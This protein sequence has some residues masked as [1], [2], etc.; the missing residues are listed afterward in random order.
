MYCSDASTLG[1]ALRESFGTEAE[2][3]RE[4][5][6]RERWRFAVVPE[7]DPTWPPGGEAPSFEAGFRP[8]GGGEY[9]E[10]D[11]LLSDD[12]EP[13]PRRAKEN[14]NV[15]ER[16]GLVPPL[17]DGLVEEAR[18]R[19]VLQGGWARLA[20]IH[21]KEGRIAL[22]GLRRAMRQKAAHGTVVLSF[23]DN[24][25]CLIAFDKGRATNKEL[26][27]LCR[28]S[29]AYQVGAEAVWRLRYIGSER[30]PTDRDSG[31]VDAGLIKPSEVRAGR[32]LLRVRAPPGLGAACA[33]PP[34]P[35]PS[36]VPLGTPE[37]VVPGEAQHPCLTPPSSRTSRLRVEPRAPVPA[38]P[39]PSTSSS[40]SSSSEDPVLRAGRE[41]REE[42][43]VP[44]PVGTLWSAM[45]REP[46]A[47]WHR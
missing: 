41:L 26:N 24:L 22:L 29:A 23:V 14:F 39:A 15:S 28:R 35:A 18:W 25:S 37:N 46:R 27:A 38:P 42:L 17:P 47:A 32:R 33:S 9:D 6:W 31:L 8:I 13:V 34:V 36:L 10:F 19:P 4:A 44:D 43:S 40:S 5:R 16:V 1:Y 7:L 12:F 20:A 21:G 30:N 11:A 2:V 3:K 45:Q